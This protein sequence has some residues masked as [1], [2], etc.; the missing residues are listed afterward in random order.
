MGI[1]G[2]QREVTFPA[3]PVSREVLDLLTG[4]LR[5]GTTDQVV[6]FT[7]NEADWR[8]CPACLGVVEAFEFIGE[9][10]MDEDGV[11]LAYDTAKCLPCGCEIR[12]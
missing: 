4:G 2:R 5:S 3:G 7:L 10:T 1:D 8:E 9:L 12:R 6:R 11:N